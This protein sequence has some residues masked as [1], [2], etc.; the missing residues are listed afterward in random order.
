MR[1]PWS[2]PG[3]NP[4]RAALSRKTFGGVIKIP[5]KA[6]RAALSHA[7]PKVFASMNG[8]ARAAFG[9]EATHVINVAP[10]CR[11]L[12]VAASYSS[13]GISGISPRRSARRV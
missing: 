8:I 2:G 5:H 1:S 13:S 3:S 6:A 7:P 4:T 10:N 12:P 11:R 9:S